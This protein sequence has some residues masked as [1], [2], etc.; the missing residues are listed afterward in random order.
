MLSLSKWFLC[1]SEA[2]DLQEN[3]AFT[4]AEKAAKRGL[5]SAEFALGYYFEIGIGG[6]K[7]IELSKSWYTK[8]WVHTYSTARL[9]SDVILLRTGRC[10]WQYRCRG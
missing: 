5:P 8:V 2:F 10:T 7:D 1:G 9:L 3:L 6:R 4:F